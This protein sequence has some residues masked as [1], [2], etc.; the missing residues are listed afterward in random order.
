MHLVPLSSQDT[1][2]A[3]EFCLS[4]LSEFV[5]DPRFEDRIDLQHLPEFYRERGGEFWITKEKGEIV[6]TL[7]IQAE[8]FR[9][10]Q[11]GVLRRFFLKPSLRGQ[12]RGQELLQTAEDFCRAKNYSFLIFGLDGGNARARPF[13]ERAGFTEFPQEL[14]PQVLRDDNDEWYFEKK[15]KNPSP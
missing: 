4:V 3:I 13:Y 6:A 12:G 15:I 5:H 10:Q 1:P 11:A 7:G 8:D 9:G 14:A 2:Q